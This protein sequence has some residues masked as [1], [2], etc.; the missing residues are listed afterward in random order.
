MKRFG[1]GAVSC[2]LICGLLVGVYFAGKALTNGGASVEARRITGVRAIPGKPWS[3]EVETHAG[4]CSSEEARR[5]RGAMDVDLVQAH[6]VYL[7]VPLVKRD[8]E[9]CLGQEIAVVRRVKLP[10]P[11]FRF[12][13]FDAG[14]SPPTRLQ[15][16]GI[17]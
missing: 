15:L 2:A 12:A 7:T 9:Y 13:Y 14:T 16:L 10:G 8:A 1:V 5:L 3:V 6:S 17:P 4:V 11:A